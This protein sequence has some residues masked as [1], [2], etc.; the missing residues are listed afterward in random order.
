MP[1]IV[2]I[3]ATEWAFGDDV[4]T[5]CDGCDAPIVHRPHAPASAVRFCVRCA[6]ALL[7]AR[8]P[9]VVFATEETLRELALFR[10]PTKGVQ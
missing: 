2:L 7:R 10:A 1:P 5:T 9:A 8:P 3:C 6:V 4:H